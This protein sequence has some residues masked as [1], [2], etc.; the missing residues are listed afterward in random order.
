MSVVCG[1]CVSPSAYRLSLRFCAGLKTVSSR[2][3]TLLTPEWFKPDLFSTSTFGA[4]PVS[5]LAFGL[6][7]RTV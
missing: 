4:F 3:V 5:I 6:L 7:L 1:F 2:G